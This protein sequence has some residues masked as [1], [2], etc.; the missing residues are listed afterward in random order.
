MSPIDFEPIEC[1]CPKCD[2]TLEPTL[3][4]RLWLTIR[5]RPWLCP[6]CRRVRCSRHVAMCEK[7]AAE[8]LLIEAGRRVSRRWYE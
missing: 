3:A 2:A 5:I 1:A 6:D 4:G 7:S 8:K